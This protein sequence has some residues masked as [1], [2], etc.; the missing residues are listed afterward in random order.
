[1]K[2]QGKMKSILTALL[3]IITLHSFAQKMK[4]VTLDETEIEI[5]ILEKIETQQL[6][7]KFDGRPNNA[8]RKEW[9]ARTFLLSN[10]KVL[11]EFYDGQS[12]LLESVTDLRKLDRIRFVKNNI[13]NLKKNISYQIKLT[14]QEGINILNSKKPKRLDQFK[15]EDPDFYDLEVYEL[16]S[17]QILYLEKSKDSNLAFLY[18]DLKRLKSENESILEQDYKYHRYDE[19]EFQMKELANGKTFMDYEP[20]E[21]L[22]Y[23]KYIKE[24]IKNHQ[25][26]KIES[27]IFVDRFSSFLYQSELGYFVLINAP[28][29]PNGAGDQMLIL[30]LRIYE[31][32]NQV[33]EAQ[34]NYEKFKE[35][36]FSSE[37]FYQQI[38][39]NYGKDF[40]DFVNGLIDSLPAILNIDANQLTLDDEGLKILDEAL[41]WHA[42]DEKLFD[43]WFPSVLAY[44][45]EFYIKNKGIGK[46]TTSFDQKENVWIPYIILEDDSSAFDIFDFYKDLLEWPGGLKSAGD[47]SGFR[48]NLRKKFKNRN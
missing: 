3:L 17:G 12:A 13:W 2:K 33:R 6:I 42:T 39:D 15:S 23:P 47:Y 22:I 11:V 4:I 48:S 9:T 27:D 34:A 38:S 20:N 29:Q 18:Q 14:Y 19:D 32:L 28:N 30:N 16:S 26:T 41:S 35:I 44:Y 40:P 24:V 43:R 37:H 5:S 46:W 10:Q 25:L 45:G 21:H 36:G 31:N 7:K 8:L 1:M